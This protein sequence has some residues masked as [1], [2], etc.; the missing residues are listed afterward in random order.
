MFLKIKDALKESEYSVKLK[1]IWLIHFPEV[2]IFG[3]Q[4]SHADEKTALNVVQLNPDE[5]NYYL[6]TPYPTLMQQLKKFH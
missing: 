6:L 1:Y 2:L 4:Q 5:N 3:I